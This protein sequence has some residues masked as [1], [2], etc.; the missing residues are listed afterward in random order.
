MK[1]T[2]LK[3]LMCTLIL[4]IGIGA[5]NAIEQNSTDELLSFEQNDQID[6][7]EDNAEVSAVSED[8]CSEVLSVENEENEIAAVSDN[9]SEVLSVENNEEEV[10]SVSENNSQVLTGSEPP[11][12]VPIG[13]PVITHSSNLKL[14]KTTNSGTMKTKEMVFGKIKMLKKNFK[15]FVLKTPSKKNKKLWKKYIKFKKTV[16]KKF[17]KSMN[18]RIKAIKKK[19]KIDWYYGI[20]P[21]FVIKGKYCTMYWTCLCYKYV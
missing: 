4:L 19:W 3:I 7:S 12:D 8:N 13:N 14:Q 6:I 1:K 2:I 10:V 15:R 16:N 20:R 17:K 18:K 9:G 11:S 5:V 21:I